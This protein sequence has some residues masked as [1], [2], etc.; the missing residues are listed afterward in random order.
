MIWKAFCSLLNSRI[1]GLENWRIRFLMSRTGHS[2]RYESWPWI[3]V[4]I[5]NRHT[6]IRGCKNWNLRSFLFLTFF[7]F[8]KENSKCFQMFRINLVGILKSATWTLS[9]DKNRTARASLNQSWTH[10]LENPRGNLWHDQVLRTKYHHS[11]KIIL[12]N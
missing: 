5:F 2:F 3:G 10:A 9:R 12:L 1:G 7:F 6:N 4:P 8:W 11:S